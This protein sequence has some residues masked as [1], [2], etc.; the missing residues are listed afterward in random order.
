MVSQVGS[1]PNLLATW[2]VT[3]RMRVSPVLANS[4]HD[5][6]RFAALFYGIVLGFFHV[7]GCSFPFCVD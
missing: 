1:I 6:K 7:K 4:E 2:T 5:N 3:S